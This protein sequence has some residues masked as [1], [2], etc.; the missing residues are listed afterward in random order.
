MPKAANNNH[1]I[2]ALD[3]VRG[4]YEKITIAPM[5]RQKFA[6][7]GV[8]KRT[9][10]APVIPLH[11]RILSDE[12]YAEIRRDQTEEL[13]QRSLLS[14]LLDERLRLED[15]IAKS[16][17]PTPIE[18][19]K[20]TLPEFKP[21]PN[22]KFHKDKYQKRNVEFYNILIA[23]EKRGFDLFYL[24]RLEATRAED[25]L[26]TRIHPD[27]AMDLWA[28][29]EH[30]LEWTEALEDPDLIINNGNA[31]K[32]RGECKGFSKVSLESMGSRFLEI[33][34]GLEKWK[35]PKYKKNCTC[36]VCTKVMAPLE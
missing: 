31:R 20:S 17:S 25:G 34:Q 2:L 1:T 24:I 35:F 23:T 3:K 11:K 27:L 26:V 19:P 10:P 8:P 5:T 15:R 29:W 6:R 36:R 21:V 30:L 14:R 33:C 12:E 18:I 7:A 28:H 4:R 9:R 32:I 16:P 13:A 22:F